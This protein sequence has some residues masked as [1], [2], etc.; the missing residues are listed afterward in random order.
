MERTG[1]AR[2]NA[3]LLVSAVLAAASLFIVPLDTVASYDYSRILKTTGTLL[4]FLL[5][6]AGLRECSA[7]DRFAQYMVGSMSTTTSLCL[8]LVFMPFFLSMLFTNDIALVTFIPLAIT[9]LDRAGMRKLILPVVVLQTAAANVGGSLTPF[10]NPHN[11]YFYQLGDVYGFTLAEYLSPLVPV[12]AVG[13]AVILAMTLTVRRA[14]LVPHRHEKAVAVDKP[15][16]AILLALFVLAVATVVA[17]IPIYVTLAVIVA[18]VAL[19]MPRVFLKTDYTILFVF[20]FLFVF[21]NSMASVEQIR[22]ALVDWLSYDPMLTTVAV[23]QFTSNLPAA[24]LLQPFT[25]NW[26]AVMVGADIGCFGTPIASMASILAIRY[27]LNE[28]DSSPRRFFC[29]FAVVNVLMLVSMS[30][31]WYLFCC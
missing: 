11:L 9:V 21:A 19:R 2:Q 28:D 31:A 3:M 7:L 16:E 18:A 25:E 24:V 5:V 26:A 29:V 15:S 1:W 22:S 12:V 13:A 27:Y 14:E 17:D 10:G 20:L 8:V 30:A 23:S 4:C 6:I